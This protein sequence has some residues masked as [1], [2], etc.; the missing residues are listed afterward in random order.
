MLHYARPSSRESA[1]EI[2]TIVGEYTTLPPDA[3]NAA[4]ARE[5]CFS[6]TE[7]L[8]GNLVD[9]IINADA[10]EPVRLRDDPR[11]RPP[12]QWLRFYRELFELH[13]LRP[14]DETGM[15]PRPT[16]CFYEA[17]T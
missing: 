4:L 6:P 1:L 9:R 12:A 14:P 11:K 17:R 5:K 2:R 15:T 3:V 13:D 7:A 8:A 16:R 10:P